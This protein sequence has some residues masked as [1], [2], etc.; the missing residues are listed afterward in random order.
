M[1]LNNLPTEEA[2]HDYKNQP[3]YQLNKMKAYVNQQRNTYDDYD[4]GYIQALED[5]LDELR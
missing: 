5:V 3:A 1:N 2:L 4:N